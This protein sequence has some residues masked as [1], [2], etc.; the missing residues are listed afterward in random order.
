MDRRR[1][2]ITTKAQER[3]EGNIMQNIK[4]YRT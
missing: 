1:R 3:I 2:T 4:N